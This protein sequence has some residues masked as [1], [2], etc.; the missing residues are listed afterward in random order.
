MFD[1]NHYYLYFQHYIA[2]I[3]LFEL[4][5][6]NKYFF[7]FTYMVVGKVFAN[8]PGDQGSIPGCVI[9]KT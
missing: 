7:T 8:G 5:K 2:I 1:H 4:F 3:V 9:R 6:K